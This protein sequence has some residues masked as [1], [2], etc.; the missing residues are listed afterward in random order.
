[1]KNYPGQVVVVAISPPNLSCLFSKIITCLRGDSALY[2]AGGINLCFERGSLFTITAN[3]DN[4]VK[5]TIKTIRE[6]QL[7][8][9]YANAVFFRIGVIVYN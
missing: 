1:M 2:Q 8:Y 6:W 4:G 9:T 5:E 7:Y 3:Q